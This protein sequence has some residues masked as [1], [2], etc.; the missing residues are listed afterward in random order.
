LSPFVR[1]PEV[2]AAASTQ[3]LGL[4]CLGLLGWLGSSRRA[5]PEVQLALFSSS[6]VRPD[7]KPWLLPVWTGRDATRCAM[8]L[9]RRCRMA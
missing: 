1:D 3:V 7:G 4:L 5:S 2:E 9:C 8:G 6:G